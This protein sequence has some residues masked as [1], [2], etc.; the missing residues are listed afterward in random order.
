MQDSAINEPMMPLSVLK[1]LRGLREPLKSRARQYVVQRMERG[2][3]TM[4]SLEHVHEGIG[5]AIGELQKDESL[6]LDSG[7][8]AR[9]MSDFHGGRSRLIEDVLGELQGTR[10]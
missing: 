6:T 10:S 8:A 5:Y 1:L 2:D 4:V 7:L 3:I 9:S